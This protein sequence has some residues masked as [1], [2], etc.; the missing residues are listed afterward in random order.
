LPEKDRRLQFIIEPLNHR[1][2][3]AAFSC[4][5]PE[6]ERYVRQQVG[7]DLRKYATVPYIL[8][9]DHK[10]IAGFYTLSQYSITLVDVP[11]DI[12]RTFP[13][14]PVVSVTL[15]GRLAVANQYLGEKLG[16]LLLVDAQHRALQL[17]KQAASAALIVDAKDDKALSFYKKYNFIELPKV[18]RRL[19]K[20]MAAIAKLFSEND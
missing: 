16:E 13:K 18:E 8:T 20:P 4:P 10:T 2:D 5:S 17:S 1:H 3:R 7:Q 15:L 6:L 19:F 9:P 12:S 14:Y 11:A